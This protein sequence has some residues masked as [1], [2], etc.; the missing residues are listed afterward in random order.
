M[1]WLAVSCMTVDVSAYRDRFAKCY[2][3]VHRFPEESLN[4]PSLWKQCDSW[5][6]FLPEE[7]GRV[8]F[9]IRRAVIPSVLC[10]VNTFCTHNNKITHA[11]RQTQLSILLTSLYVCSRGIMFLALWYF[12]TFYISEICAFLGYYAPLSGSSV[13]TFRDN[14]SVPFSR[15]KKSEDFL[16]LQDVTD[17]I[18]WNVGTAFLSLEDGNDRLSRNVGTEVPLNAA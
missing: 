8:S 1:D 17:R 2:L 4:S 9:S 15:V 13:L 18:S 5:S 7:P 10:Y 14:L 6:V 12:I 3:S 16:T 11:F